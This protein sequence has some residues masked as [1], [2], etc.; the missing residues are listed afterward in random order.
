MAFDE[1][2][3]ND[4]TAILV[5]MCDGDRHAADQL[6]P[7]VY[8]E[9]RALAGHLFE[10]VRPAHTLQPTALV[11]EAY[12]KLICAN[13][14]NWEGRAHF[15]AVA[16][17][18]MRQVLADHARKRN[19]EKRGGRDWHRVTLDDALSAWQ[20]SDVDV[21]EFSEIIDELAKLSPRQAQIVDLRVFGGLTIEESAHVLG[22]G[23]TTVKSDWQIAKAW[24]KRA[25]S[26]KGTR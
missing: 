9:L 17:K 5:R 13:D 2:N 20:S 10:H 18:A 16:A 15:F 22:V 3:S 11:H 8:G 1:S 4:A 12:V 7:L 19:A 6:L 26:D 23:P 21:L 25:L 24:L 14:P